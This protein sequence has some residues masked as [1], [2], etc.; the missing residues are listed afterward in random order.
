MLIRV[1]IAG[2]WFEAPERI[3]SA[4]IVQAT[5]DHGIPVLAATLV[6]IL[7]SLNLLLFTFN[8]IPFP[9]LDGSSI[10][11]LFLSHEGAERYWQALRAPGFNMIGL[12]VAWRLFDVVYPAIHLFFVNALYTG[13]GHYG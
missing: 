5:V 10:P 12:I 2:G 7:F 4:H 11:L 9:P 6:S 3:F 13:I 8:L 1:G